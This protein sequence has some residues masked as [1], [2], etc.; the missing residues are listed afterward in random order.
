[1]VL[2]M[3]ALSVQPCSHGA[4]AREL[5]TI[6]DLVCTQAKQGNPERGQAFLVKDDHWQ[7]GSIAWQNRPPQGKLV[8]SWPHPNEGDTVLFDVTAIVKAELRDKKLSLCLYEKGW[9]HASYASRE[10]PREDFRPTLL[11]QRP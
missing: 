3:V 11:V 9:H 7:E 1:M 4:S 10:H 6:Y 5:R 8:A 2:G